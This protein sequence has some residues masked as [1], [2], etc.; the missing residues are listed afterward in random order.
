MIP[1]VLLLIVSGKLF[2]GGYRTIK[3][4]IGHKWLHTILYAAGSFITF[5]SAI[6]LFLYTLHF[7]LGVE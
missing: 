4:P 6:A 7:V 3:R 5:Y 2:I 1:I